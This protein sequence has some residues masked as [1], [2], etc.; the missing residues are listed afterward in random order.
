MTKYI[1][2]RLL[3]MIPVIIGSTF[4]IF[5]MVFAL[6]GNPLAGKCGERPCPPAFVEKFRADHNLDDPLPIRYVKYLGDLA[7][8]NF[9]TTFQGLNVLDELQKRY[10]ITVKLAVIALLFEAIIGV[11]AGV[12]AG[13]RKGKFI[14]NLVLVSTLVVISIPTFVIGSL[15]QTIFGVKLGWFPV[16]TPSKPGWYDL[17]LPGLVLGSLSL[18]YAA[19]LTRTNLAENLR[20]DYVRTAV[21]KGLSRPRVIGVHTLRNSLIPVVTFLGADFGGLLGGAIIT[22]RI[23]NIRG[24]GGY[25]FQSINS[26]DGTAVVGAVTMLVIVYLFMNLLVDI[27]Y[28]VLD[29]RISHD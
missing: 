21:A 1:V 20:A 2:R 17:L 16:T 15:A 3:Q 23:F 19:R 4:L 24:V 9:G 28:G 6:P 22:E 5:A 27:L 18:A 8:G 25:I 10:L 13:I 7:H 12:L 14:D 11:L 26:R 29:P